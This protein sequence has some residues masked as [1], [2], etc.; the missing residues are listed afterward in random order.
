MNMAVPSGKDHFIGVIYQKRSS[1]SYILDLYSSKNYTFVHCS[2]QLVLTTDQSSTCNISGASIDKSDE[3]LGIT[4]WEVEKTNERTVDFAD[5]SIRT[6]DPNQLL[7]KIRSLFHKYKIVY[8]EN[9][10]DKKTFSS[11]THDVELHE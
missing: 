1:D 2:S 7:N 3:T 11:L 8:F 5:P 4:F 9:I 10:V 6:L